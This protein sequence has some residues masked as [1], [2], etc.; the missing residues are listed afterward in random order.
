MHIADPTDVEKD[1]ADR[2]HF[3]VNIP[4][5]K[6]H[7]SD[8]REHNKHRQQTIQHQK[9]RHLQNTVHMYERE[10]NTIKISTAI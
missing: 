9:L 1:T 4:G 7:G 3:L 10:P 2:N 6:K 8:T 5:G